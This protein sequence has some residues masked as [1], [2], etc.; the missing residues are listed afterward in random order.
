MPWV[1]FF[2]LTA[3]F[4]L[5]VSSFLKRKKKQ[6]IEFGKADFCIS[7]YL[8]YSII[9]QLSN[10]L[11]ALQN[12][13]FV[14]IVI[15]VLLYY[16]LKHLFCSI[17][18]LSLFRLISFMVLG[19]CLYSATQLLYSIANNQAAIQQVKFLFFN[20]GILAI[21]LA[22]IF[23][24]HIYLFRFDKKVM[25]ITSVINLV[26]TIVLIIAVQSR[27]AILICTIS[28]VSYCHERMIVRNGKIKLKN[29][30]ISL[31]LFA[32]VFAT[33]FYYKLASSNGRLLIWKISLSHASDNIAGIGVGNF[34]YQYPLWQ[35]GFFSKKGSADNENLYLAD[36]SFYAFNELLQLLIEGGVISFVFFAGFIFFTL[37]K[38]LRAPGSGEVRVFTLIFIGITLSTF[39]SYP[40][41]NPSIFLMLIL[42]GAYVNQ[43]ESCDN[44][45]SGPTFSASIF[46]R[47]LQVTTGLFLLGYFASQYVALG[48]W[49]QAK[50][51]IIVNEQTAIKYYNK[52][53]PLLQHKGEFVFNYGAQCFEI[54]RY[55]K[56]SL[57]F[58]KCV[59]IFSHYSLFIY[60]GANHQKIGQ[61]KSAEKCFSLA[62]KMLPSRIYPKSLLAKLYWE[63]GDTSKA[64]H[65]AREVIL[66][67]TKVES[68]SIDSI[69][70]EMKK[71]LDY[72][73]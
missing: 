54:G 28:L 8:V 53:Y 22:V 44:K 26:L 59:C 37:Q 25:Q 31:F 10:G 11:F 36:M 30:L 33:L 45:I 56:A 46:L 6:K 40:L 70:T 19:V 17:N 32:F 47:I 67:K 24:L 68:H 23:P 9:L 39:F 63:Q 38:G 65:K 29:I 3:A 57:L 34:A 12:E 20:S 16:S 21:L 1:L 14:S 51:N 35:A 62:E 49:R 2:Y 72:D 27:T 15:F 5:V 55:E 43:F 60:K 48:W 50:K 4:L 61:Y 66:F 71:L 41:H 42:S 7:A 58:D 64:F 13:H 18:I 69:K 73:K 52:A